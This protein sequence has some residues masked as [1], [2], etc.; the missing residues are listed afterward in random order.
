MSNNQTRQDIIETCDRIK[1]LLLSK[2][3]KYGDAALNPARIMSKANPVE[4]ILVRIDDKLNRISKG[5]GLL[6]SD[7]DVVPDLAGYFILLIIALERQN[8]VN[9]ETA[10][11]VIRDYGERP[12]SIDDAW[13]Y[14]NKPGENTPSEE[15]FSLYRAGHRRPLTPDEC[16]VDGIPSTPLINNGP[17]VVGSRP[18]QMNII[19][20]GEG[21]GRSQIK[22]NVGFDSLEQLLEHNGIETTPEQD[23]ENKETLKAWEKLLTYKLK[24]YGIEFPKPSEPL[25][26]PWEEHRDP[27]DPECIANWPDCTNGG[28]DPKCCRFPKSCSCGGP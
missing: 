15:W 10:K 13:D 7:E 18:G 21:V 3:E 19:C 8:E 23:R 12:R 27:R 11:R 14:E 28:Y 1:E 26:D 22:N 6:A 25:E 2:N 16:R 4:Q 5:A 9:F 20:S 17:S 24:Q